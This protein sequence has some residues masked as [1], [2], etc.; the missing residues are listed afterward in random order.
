VST[1]FSETRS[2]YALVVDIDGKNVVT[3]DVPIGQWRFVERKDVALN[4]EDDVDLLRRWLDE[5][6]DKDR[7]VVRLHFVGS[8]TLSLH[9]V[10]QKHLL[11]ASDLF[12]ALDVRQDDLLVVPDDADFADLGFSGFADGTVQR[13]RGAMAEGGKESAVAREALMLLLRLAKGVA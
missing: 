2:G 4:T 8:V 13:L 10:V 11:E 1:D 6:G 7:S 12:A 9:A 3:E 5:L